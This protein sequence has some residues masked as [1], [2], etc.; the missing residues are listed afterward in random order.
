[1]VFS[2]ICDDLGM[3]IT[4]SDLGKTHSNVGEEEK[5]SRQSHNRKKGEKS[6][7]GIIFFLLFVLFYVLLLIIALF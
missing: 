3:G 2:V 7:V 6:G 4:P 5:G 1:M